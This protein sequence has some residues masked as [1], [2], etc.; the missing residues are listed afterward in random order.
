MY[1]AIQYLTDLDQY[2]SAKVRPRLVDLYNRVSISQV[3]IG[4][5]FSMT[6][7][8]KVVTI[9]IINCRNYVVIFCFLFIN[10][11]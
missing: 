8:G 9:I 2:Y 11:S 7:F 10:L 5:V 3:H 1:D 6:G 4:I